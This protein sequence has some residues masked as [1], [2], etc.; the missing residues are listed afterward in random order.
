MMKQKLPLAVLSAIFS[1]SALAAPFSGMDPRSMAMGGTGVS[2]ATGANAGY[3]NPALLALPQKDEDFKLILPS[4]GA[5]VADPDELVTELE[6]FQDGNVIDDFSDAINAYNEILD[7]LGTID[8]TELLSLIKIKAENVFDTG[9][10]LR[11]ELVDLSDKALEFS[12]NGSV[13]AA[14]PDESLGWSVSLASWGSGGMLLSVAQSDQNEIQSVLDAVEDISNGVVLS[15]SDI[16]TLAD[17]TNP[18]NTLDSALLGRG[19]VV[20]EIGISLARKFELEGVAF[21]AGVTPRYLSV[22]TFD[23]EINI[24]EAENITYY[25]G[26]VSDTGVTAD[27]GVARDFGNGWRAGFVAKNIISQEFLT[28][29]NYTIELNPML[30]A[31]VSH[32]TG[33]GTVALDVDLTENDPTG[34]DSA[35]QYIAI[36]GELNGWNWVQ[37]RAGYRKNISENSRDVF[38]IGAGVSP[39]GIV[40]LDVAI[41]G[42]SNE[43]AAS[44]QLG[45]SF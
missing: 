29:N 5:G 9:T 40:H 36:G 14:M 15:P 13:V 20:S 24:D 41:A 19:I 44:A 32:H 31:G 2:S 42:N 16:S 7:S 11:N 37:I 8:P 23:Y 21:S 34:M 17:L 43:A 3:F 25:E 28:A 4:F 33:W 12:L 27:F 45:L 18:T 26:V 39:F 38:T 1:T 6:D 30:R 10:I 35:T 22:E